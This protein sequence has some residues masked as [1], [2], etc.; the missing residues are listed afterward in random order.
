MVLCRT[1]DILYAADRLC[2]ISH[3][4]RLWEIGSGV[5]AA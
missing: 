1:H 2:G 3:R 5:D 4:T